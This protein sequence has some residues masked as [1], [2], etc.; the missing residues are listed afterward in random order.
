M[1]IRR[2]NVHKLSIQIINYKAYEGVKLELLHGKICWLSAYCFFFAF[3][4]INSSVYKI[5]GVAFKG[6]TVQINTMIYHVDITSVVEASFRRLFGSS[7]ST[8]I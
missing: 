7:E 1:Q 5:C 8:G 2:N 4:I 6:F 3:R